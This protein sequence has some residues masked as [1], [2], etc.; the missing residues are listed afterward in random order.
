L[1]LPVKIAVNIWGC[2][3]GGN[4]SDRQLHSSIHNFAATIAN[5]RVLYTKLILRGILKSEFCAR[6]RCI[7][8]KRQHWK[9]KAVF[10]LDVDVFPS[11]II[12]YMLG[13]V[14]GW[15]KL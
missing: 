9:D 8:Q 4:S 10:Y 6:N 13:L 5:V 11:D 12:V 15:N 14:L 1:R 2:A 7:W 3:Q